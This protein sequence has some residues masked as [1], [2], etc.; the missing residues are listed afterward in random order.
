ML[1]RLTTEDL[2]TF[3]TKTASINNDSPITTRSISKAATTN[4]PGQVPTRVMS[5]FPRP[6]I[7]LRGVVKVEEEPVQFKKLAL[8]GTLTDSTIGHVAIVVPGPGLKKAQKVK[9]PKTLPKKRPVRGNFKVQLGTSRSSA[10]AN[11]V[12]F[13]LRARHEDL[14][15]NLKPTFQKVKIDG[16]GTLY[17]IQ[18]GPFKSWRAA[19]RMCETIK[20]RAVNCLPVSGNG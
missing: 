17:R 6:N 18:V 8:R 4:V 1:A 19:Q 11:K 2:Y 5:E 3:P 20:Q 13:F 15:E 14:L 7:G 9:R 12:W 10:S 16:G